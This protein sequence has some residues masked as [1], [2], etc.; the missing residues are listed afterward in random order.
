MLCQYRWVI[1]QQEREERKRK[2]VF[3]RR[4]SQ[5]AFVLLQCSR[6]VRHELV[7]WNWSN[8]FENKAKG[9]RP[10][11]HS[12][13][14]RHQLEAWVN[15]IQSFKCPSVPGPDFFLFA[16]WSGMR[17]RSIERSLL[18]YHSVIDFK[19]QASQRL[20]FRQHK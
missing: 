9:N 13:K 18:L 3:R 4:N 11:L 14:Q 19:S 17:E 1:Q 2:V 16:H 20:F 12:C 8:L 5:F 7:N 15:K 6:F 10:F